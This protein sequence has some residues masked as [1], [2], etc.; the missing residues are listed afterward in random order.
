MLYLGRRRRTLCEERERR[1]LGSHPSDQRIS[2]DQHWRCAGDYKQWPV[3]GIEH[4][5]VANGTTNRISVPI[6]VN[7]RPGEVIG[8]LP[9]VIEKGEKPFYKQV[10]YSDYVKH[11]FHKAHDGK[12]TVEFAMI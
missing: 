7:P 5:V 6:F 10:R 2:R 8:P 4:R 11:F 12:K 9:E 1:N 3:Q